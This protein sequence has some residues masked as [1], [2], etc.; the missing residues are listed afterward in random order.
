MGL[1]MAYKL[2]L[3]KTEPAQCD[4]Y[5]GCYCDP[6]VTVEQLAIVDLANSQNYELKQELIQLVIN[7][8]EARNPQ[9]DLLFA[10]LRQKGWVNIKDIEDREKKLQASNDYFILDQGQ[11]TSYRLDTG[12]IPVHIARRLADE[13]VHV[14]RAV[15]KT[16]LKALMDDKAKK[17]YNDEV[18]RIKKDKERRAAAS[19]AKKEKKRQQEIEKAKKILAEAENGKR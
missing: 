9:D 16:S 8:L 17:A 5:D 13:K 3:V 6:E 1:K 11:Y 4:C 18:A 19:V 7:T 2:L 10:Q 14:V 15:T 12:A